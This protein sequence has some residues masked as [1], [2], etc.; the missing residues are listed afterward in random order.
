MTLKE[1]MKLYR[2]NK[3]WPVTP[4]ENI[5]SWIVS[6]WRVKEIKK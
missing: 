4:R 6:S 3:T 1:M 5:N 2:E